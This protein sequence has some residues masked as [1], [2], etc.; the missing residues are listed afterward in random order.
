[1]TG[2]SAM[3][4]YAALNYEPNDTTHDFQIDL[5]LAD[6]DVHP[7]KVILDVNTWENRREITN[8]S[9][10]LMASVTGNARVWAGQVAPCMGGTAYIS[11]RNF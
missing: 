9:V 7:W 1:M 3:K 5:P 11:W 4:L 6:D 2:F 10:Y 8:N